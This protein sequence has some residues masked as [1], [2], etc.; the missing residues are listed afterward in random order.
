[1]FLTHSTQAKWMTL[2]GSWMQVCYRRDIQGCSTVL[3]TVP[4]ASWASRQVLLWET[5]ELHSLGSWGFVHL[6]HHPPC[7]EHAGRSKNWH[8]FCFF[9]HYYVL[10][11]MSKNEDLYIRTHVYMYWYLSGFLSINIA[12]FVGYN[13][14][15]NIPSLCLLLLWQSK[16]F[17][18][19]LTAWG[20]R[21]PPNSCENHF[22][23]HLSFIMPQFFT[24][25]PNFIF[26][27]IYR[28][29]WLQTISDHINFK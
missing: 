7:W 20:E 11:K 23:R 22:Y 10:K 27:H 3:R 8:E 9:E 2:T 12:T 6:W 26:S 19:W 14:F 28:Q 15:S 13:F 21:S 1:M 17:H 25:L 4:G 29:S 16:C 5:G 18:T 24:V